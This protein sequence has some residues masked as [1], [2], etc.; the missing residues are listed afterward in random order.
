MPTV[1]TDEKE[2]EIDY[3]LAFAL[4]LE[5]AERSPVT[6]KNY[7]CDLNYF[8][9]WFEQKT[10]IK[11]SPEQITPTDLRNY[12]HYLSE[13]LLLKPKTVNRKLSSLKS[14][15]NWASTEELIPEHRT[16]RMPQP[17]KEEKMGPQ[18]LDRNEQHALVRTVEQSKNQRDITIIQLLLN[19]GL[20]VSELCSL[21]WSDIKLTPRKGRLIV[22]S[23][24]GGKRREIPLNKDARK[25]LSDLGYSNHKG[26]RS[27]IFIGQRGPMTPR[28]VESMFRKYVAHTE[29]DEV[30]PHKLRHTF[31]KNLIEAG[32]SLEKVA[33]L[34]GH[35]NLETTRLYCSPGDHDLEAAVDLIGG[36]E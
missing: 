28:G 20:R 23:G 32:V 16:P 5:E 35:E 14:F 34:A 7:L 10:D 11:L 12:K 29:L 13:V 4:F 33:M 18:W 15:L 26:Q 31:C 1:T 22:R 19:T 21:M 2:T 17:I 3:L 27:A 36:F 24:K 8:G 6:I 30:T 9:K 25:V